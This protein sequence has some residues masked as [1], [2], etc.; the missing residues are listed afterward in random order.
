MPAT[1]DFANTEKV[2]KVV[3]FL[4]VADSV[5]LSGAMDFERLEKQ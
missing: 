2:E 5:H 4:S 3:G 1:T